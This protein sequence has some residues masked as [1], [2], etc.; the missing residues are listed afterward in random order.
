MCGIAGMLDRSRR[1]PATEDSL[2]PMP[3]RLRHRG[4]A[5]FGILSTP[6]VHRQFI[7]HFRKAQ[8][9]DSNDAIKICKAI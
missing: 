6:L 7:T 4:P 8:P 5:E 3:G 2:R 1:Q 9:L